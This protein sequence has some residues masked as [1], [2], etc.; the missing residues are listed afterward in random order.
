MDMLV[1]V[2]PADKHE[3][4]LSSVHCG[5]QRPCN[6]MH[7]CLYLI[8]QIAIAPVLIIACQQLSPLV[9]AH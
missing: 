7:R 4:T 9:D 8:P 5:E 1:F 2:V 6:R 3:F